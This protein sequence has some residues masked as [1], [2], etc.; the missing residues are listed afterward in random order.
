MAALPDAKPVDITLSD[1]NLRDDFPKYCRDLVRVK[2]ENGKIV[3][4]V[5]NRAQLHVHELIEQQ[6]RERGYIRALILKA[7]QLGIS[8]YFSARFYYKSTTTM[9]KRTFILTHEDKATQNLFAMAKRVHDY[10][11]PKYKNIATTNNANELDFL[12]INAGYR[13]ATA[14]SSAG[15]GRSDTIQLFH[16]SEVAFWRDAEEHYAGALQAVPNV[17]NSEVAMEST[18]NGVGGVFWDQWRKARRGLGDFI[19]IFCP[20]FWKEGYWDKDI[21]SFDPSPEILEYGE[22]YDLCLEQMK[23]MDAKIIVLQGDPGTISW[24]F[25]QEYPANAAEAFQTSGDDS[26]I[27]PEAVMRARKFDGEVFEFQPII[28][29]V[30]TA[31]GGGDLTRII[32]RQ[33]RVA[34]KLWDETINVDDEM[35]IA[36]RVATAINDTHCNM[37]FIDITGVGAGVRD[38]LIQLGFDDKVTGINFGHS[39]HEPTRAL[40]RRD[41]MWL[42]MKEWMNDAAGCDVPDD[43]DLQM[44]LCGPTGEY[45]FNS[46]FIL[47]AKKAMKARLKFSPDGGDALAL[48]FAEQVRI[49]EESEK[50]PDW[51]SKLTDRHKP[52]WMSG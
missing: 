7:R 32:S 15:P 18:A 29:G 26:W 41:E 36:D 45:D 9:G 19:P 44:H 14:Q 13:V 21:A 28:L 2:N 43:D 22:T 42:R 17:P 1:E 49:H 46:R 34:G 23:W 35:L 39:A 5:L 4:L 10:M 20:W 48:T 38:R 51:M 52:T 40:R 50:P 6:Y 8:T 11:D 30:D 12:A 33:G 3:P 47:E 25:R 16:G 24:R 27:K 37:C 31:R